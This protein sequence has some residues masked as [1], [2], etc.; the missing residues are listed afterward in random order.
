LMGEDLFSSRLGPSST[1]GRPTRA[2]G[3]GEV[4]RSSQLGGIFG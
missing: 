2:R 1:L 4:A 3:P